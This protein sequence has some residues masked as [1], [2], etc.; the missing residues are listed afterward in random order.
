MRRFVGQDTR[1]STLASIDTAVIHMAADARLEHRLG[2]LDPEHVVLAW[3]DAIEFVGERSERPLDWCVNCSVY[4][5]RACFSATG[6]SLA[7]IRL[8]VGV[9]DALLPR[10][11]LL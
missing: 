2:D 10:K 7:V 4:C 11:A 5:R 6:A 3:F 9:V 8:T 1:P